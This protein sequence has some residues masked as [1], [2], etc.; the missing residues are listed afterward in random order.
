MEQVLPRFLSPVSLQ[1]YV[2]GVCSSGMEQAL[3]SQH[4]HDATDTMA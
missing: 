2:L 1:E 3:V 4:V